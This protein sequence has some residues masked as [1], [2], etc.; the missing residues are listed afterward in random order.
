MTLHLIGHVELPEHKG[1]GGFDHAAVHAASGHVYVAHTA[2]DA[3]DVFDA[4]GAAIRVDSRKSG[5]LVAGNE[6]GIFRSDDGGKSW[7]SAGAAGFQQADHFAPGNRIHLHRGG[8][9]QD[10]ARYGGVGVMYNP[11]PEPAIEVLGG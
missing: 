1:K 4:V 2:N 6:E 11:M 8:H 10:L 5:V 7:R 3:V 9:A